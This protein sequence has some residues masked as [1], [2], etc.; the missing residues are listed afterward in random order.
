[1]RES[2]VRVNEIRVVGKREKTE[3]CYIIKAYNTLREKRER[4]RRVP[5]EELAAAVIKYYVYSE[6][7]E[8][9]Y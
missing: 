7:V 5:C 1:M 6:C 8:G 2:A 3:N 9:C 4:V